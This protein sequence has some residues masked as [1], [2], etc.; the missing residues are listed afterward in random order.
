MEAF[1][2]TSRGSAEFVL[3]AGN[4]GIGKT[5]LV[6]EIYKPVT[7]QRG[8]FISGKFNQFQK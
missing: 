4:S 1:G 5:C 2:R 3:V 7:R 6:K 8:Y